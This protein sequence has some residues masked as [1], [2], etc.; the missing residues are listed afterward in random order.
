M[1][2]WHLSTKVLFSEMHIFRGRKLYHR[3]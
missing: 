1:C 2:F 3:I